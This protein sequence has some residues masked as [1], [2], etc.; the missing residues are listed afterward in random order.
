MTSTGK[1]SEVIDLLQK[2]CSGNAIKMV[3][4]KELTEKLKGYLSNGVSFESHLSWEKA[5]KA[6]N[7]KDERGN[8]TAS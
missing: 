7:A 2:I 6:P 1:W 3:L 5:K 8:L 4:F